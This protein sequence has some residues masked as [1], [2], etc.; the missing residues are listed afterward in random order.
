LEDVTGPSEYVINCPR[1]VFSVAFSPNG[2]LLATGCYG[3]AVQ[4]WDLE[5]GETRQEYEVRGFVS[6]AVYSPNGKMMAFISAVQ[7]EVEVEVWNQITGELQKKIV[8]PSN[9][10]VSDCLSLEFSPDNKTLMFA[11]GG[12][13]HIWDTV[14]E[15]LRQKL[16]HPG[17][18]EVIS[19]KLSCDGSLICSSHHNGTGIRDVF[20]T[21]IWDQA[22]GHQLHNL[23]D[24]GLYT[25]CSAFSPRDRLLATAHDDITLRLWGPTGNNTQEELAQHERRVWS[26]AFSS[27][28]KILASGS[29]DYTTRLWDSETGALLQT[30]EHQ[31]E[32]QD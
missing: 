2:R 4:I 23:E 6:S 26:L 28:A 31:C 30:L 27:D 20:A 18:A 1:N 3:Y 10:R 7:A 19:L 13:I 8:E 11:I 21:V 32:F 16:Q 24:Q 25:T 9:P 12:N 15:T 17:F 5:T 22:T 14:A 29:S